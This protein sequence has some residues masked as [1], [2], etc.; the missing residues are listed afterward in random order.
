MQEKKIEALTQPSCFSRLA[1]FR[2]DRA[3]CKD[4]F[5]KSS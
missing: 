4:N 3:R 2:Q 5:L 1:T